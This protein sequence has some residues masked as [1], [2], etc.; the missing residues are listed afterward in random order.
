MIERLGHA[1]DDG[2]TEAEP[3]LLPRAGERRAA[4]E[5]VEDQLP[6]L[7]GDAAAGIG[8]LHADAADPAPR[9]QDD[10]ARARVPD[11]VRDEVLQD[12]LQELF[13]KKCTWN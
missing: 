8:H 1:A 4:E 2:Q 3:R 12:A 6:V 9:R 11:R 13:K 7:C 10:P 5:L